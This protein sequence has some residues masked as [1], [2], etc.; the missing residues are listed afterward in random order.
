MKFFEKLALR[1]K[2]TLLCV[3]LDPDFE[4]MPEGWPQNAAGVYDFCKRIVD[5]TADF[6]AAFKPQIAYFSAQGF[7]RV[8]FDVISYIHAEYPEIPV[9]LDAKRGDIG[10]TAAQYAQEI[11]M[12]Y[13]ADATTIS[14]YMGRDSLEPW[15]EYDDHG[16][17]ILCRTSNPGGA[18]LQNLKADNAPIFEHV[19][20]MVLECNANQQCGLVMGA[21][22][23]DEIKKVREIAPDLPFLLP[24]VGAQGG[25]I[26][27]C[28]KAG[29]VSKENPGILLN[30]SRKILYA[31]RDSKDFEAAARNAAQTTRKIIQIARKMSS[32][33]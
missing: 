10:T 29:F 13:E 25:S 12:R 19:A 32:S 4:L 24:G 11:F 15:L 14:P 18:D 6:A 16:L 30:S 22:Y 27:E 28:V 5:A 1:Q 33:N 7:E 23:P 21:T 2:K 20:K 3:G 8:L 9:I 17:F 31:S 26:A